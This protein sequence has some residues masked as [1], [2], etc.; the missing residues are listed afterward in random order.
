MVRLGDYELDMGRVVR[1]VLESR[2]RRILVQLPEGLKRHYP[3]LLKCI[4]ERVGLDVE[5]YLDASPAYGSCLI[6]LESTGSYDLVLHVGHDPYPYA[7]YSSSKIVFLDLE[8]VGSEPESTI[9]KLKRFL[10]SASAVRVAI[11]TTNQHKKL[12]KM[13]RSELESDGFSVVAGPAVVLGCYVPL[14][15][16]IAADAIVVVAGG[17]FH[18]IGVGMVA[19]NSL[20]VRVDPYTRDVSD[21]SREVYRFTSRR[22]KKMAE[23]LEARSWGILVGTAGQYRPWLVGRLVRLLSE[24]DLNYYLYVAPVLTAEVLRNLDSPEVGAYVVTS[25]PRVA[26]DD[27]SDFEKPVLTPSEALR[28]IERLDVGEYPD[29]FLEKPY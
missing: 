17:F 12:S 10:R 15:M 4:K 21:V 25:C 28:V 18:A 3:A 20:V 23:A 11:V 7:T 22:L 1:A 27:L 2:A 13:I 8:Y 26:V 29:S 6:D 19:R 24:R 5:V 16:G 14:D 9:S